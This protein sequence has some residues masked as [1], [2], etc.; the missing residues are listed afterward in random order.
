QLFYHPATSQ[1]VVIDR[2]DTMRPGDK[3]WFWT[4]RGVPLRIEVGPRDVDAGHVVV[5]SRLDGSKEIVPVAGL[6]RA[7][8][9]AKLAGIQ[10]GLFDRALAR[11]DAGIRTVTTYKDFLN[12]F[13]EGRGFARCHFNP[14][15][16]VEAQIKA[17]TKATVRLITR[18]GDAA[19]GTCIFSGEPSTTEVIFGVSY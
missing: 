18:D 19:P 15:R 1:Q 14:S 2:R 6:T 5:K 8:M 12:H 10:Q 4:Q 13:A 3:H 7:W 17:E 9:D 16:V 11:R